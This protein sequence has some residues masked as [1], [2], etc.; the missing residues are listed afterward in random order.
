MLN[1]PFRR[2][3]LA[4]RLTSLPRFDDKSSPKT[5]IKFLTDGMLVRELMLDSSLKRYSVVVLDEAHERSC[6]SEHFAVKND[7]SMTQ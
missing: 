1:L 3:E 7:L 4:F 2:A 6:E 5:K